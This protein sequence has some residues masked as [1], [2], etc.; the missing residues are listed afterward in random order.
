VCTHLRTY[1]DFIKGFK[2]LYKLE[3]DTMPDRMRLTIMMARTRTSSQPDKS[4]TATQPSQSSA[5]T[6][7]DDGAT[8]SHSASSSRQTSDADQNVPQPPLP[9]QQ[10]NVPPQPYSVGLD[11]QAS[12]PAS[13]VD[14]R[15]A[16][17]CPQTLSSG[18]NRPTMSRTYFATAIERRAR[19]EHGC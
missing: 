2:A 19:S 1:P 3:R 12:P 15:L 14:C 4:Q 5:P 16:V 7:D 17:D 8:P 11:A 10:A 6:V 13:P 18:Q 9:P